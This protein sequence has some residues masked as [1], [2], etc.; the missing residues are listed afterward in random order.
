MSPTAE[1]NIAF[2]Q[3]R[4]RLTS[5]SH[6]AKSLVSGGIKKGYA[7]LGGQFKRKGS[8]VLGDAAS[9]ASRNTSLPQRIKQ[10]GL[11]VI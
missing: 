1:K 7:V 8:N 5:S 10:G 2:A 11:S 4:L 3:C 9:L 6:C